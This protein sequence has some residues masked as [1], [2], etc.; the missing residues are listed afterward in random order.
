MATPNQMPKRANPLH[1]QILSGLLANRKSTPLAANV[2]DE[3]IERA[4]KR[5]IK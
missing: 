5:W 2:S 1:Q 3:N 4:A